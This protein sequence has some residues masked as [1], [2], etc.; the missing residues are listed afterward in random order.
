LLQTIAS[1]GVAARDAEASLC[2]RFGRR[3]QL[4]G[5]KHLRDADRAVDLAQAVML[6]VLEAARA[7]RIED[8]LRL[9]RFVLGTCRNIA[10]RMRQVD[11]RAQPTDQA[12][13]ESLAAIPLVPPVWPTLETVDAGALF[14]CL[15]GLEP[16][17][18][19]VIQLS[20]NEEL[21]TEE[22]AVLVDTTAGNVRVLRHRALAQLRQCLD[23]H[24]EAVQ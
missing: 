4:Y 24:K 13:L 16:R 8:P 9:D 12:A 15:R 6:A 5:R 23:A 2:R 19:T 7:G 1:G 18:R 3:A 17:G 21:S 10:L 11:A 20:F 22:I 14:R